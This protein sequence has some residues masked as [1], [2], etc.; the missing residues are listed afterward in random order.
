MP[1]LVGS[2]ICLFLFVNERDLC[3]LNSVKCN[4]H[5]ISSWIDCLCVTQGTFVR[6]V[7][8]TVFIFWDAN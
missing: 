1:F 5:Q 8:V 2:V 3:L 4:Y 6:N 7:S